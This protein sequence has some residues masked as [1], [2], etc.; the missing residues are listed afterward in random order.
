MPDHGQLFYNGTVRTIDPACPVAGAVAV[1]QGQIIAVGSRD[2]CVK[3]LGKGYEPVDMQGGALVPGFIDTHMHPVLLIFFAMNCDLGGVSSMAELQRKLRESLLRK[4]DDSWLIGLNFD[5]QGLREK[6]VP[7]RHDLDAV[8]S[9]R[10]LAVIK[11]DGHSVFANTRAIEAAGITASTP[12]PEAG[13]IE[14][15]EDGFPSGVFRETALQLVMNSMPMPEMN[16]LMDSARS[17]FSRLVSLGITSAGIVLQTSAEGPAGSAGAFDVPAMQL[18]SELCPLSLYSLLITPDIAGLEELRTSSLNSGSNRLGGVKL[19]ADGTFGSSTAYMQEPFS[20]NAQKRGLL[21]HP[22]EELYELMAAAHKAGWQVC[23]HAIGDAANRL[24]MEL[25]TR[26]FRQFPRSGCRHRIEHASIMDA[27]VMREMAG[28]GVL[29][30]TQPMFIH[31]EKGWLPPRLGTERCRSVYPLRSFLET[32]IRVGGASDAPIESQDVLQAIGC[33]VTREGFEPHQCISVEQALRMYTLD[34]AYLQFEEGIK[35]S[36]TPGK[37][38][39]LVLLSDD[40]FKVKPDRIKDIEVVR[41]VVG[42]KV[43]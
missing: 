2:A 3:A 6:R 7:D 8:S 12:D 14:R 41:T 31:S 19:F 21:M 25:Y 40:P 1:R 13:A 35:G 17:T 23:I 36:I 18:F 20:D 43:L 26:L 4:G 9:E 27:D 38:G 28:L 34:A 29:V 5:E 11:H 32:G 15:E 22:P 24:C 39:D 10:P 42:G 33:C 16:V 37:R 30:S